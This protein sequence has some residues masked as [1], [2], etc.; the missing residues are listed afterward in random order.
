MNR[1]LPGLLTSILLLISMSSALA[2]DNGWPRTLPLERGMVTIYSPQVEKMSGNTIH[3]RAALAYRETPDSE[4]VF[5]AGWFESPAEIDT[6][7]R[8]VQPGELK[9]TQT[10]FP[11]GTHDMQSELSAAL[12]L[13]SPA[14]NLDFSLDELEEALEMSKAESKAAQNLNTAPPEIIYR[15]I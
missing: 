8:I 3:F 2:Q 14:W 12:A 1:L 10:R 15:D 7:N 9:V 5:G 6:T 4:P 13:E 11:A